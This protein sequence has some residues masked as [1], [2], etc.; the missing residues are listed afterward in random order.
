M[1][2][3][4][5]TELLSD[6][7]YRSD[8]AASS[9]RGTDDTARVDL[10]QTRAL[11]GG[12]Y[13]LGAALRQGRLGDVFAAEDQTGTDLGIERRVALQLIDP[14]VIVGST[15]AAELS[16]CCAA[17]RAA[18]HPNVAKV[19]NFGREGRTFFV[20]ME[21]LDGLSLRA[22]LDEAA[23][24][25]L[26]EDEVLP[27]VA[28][29]GEAIGYLHAKEIVHGSLR[30]TNVFVT[31]DHAVKV[32]D[33]PFTHLK[34]T[35][36]YYVEDTDDAEPDAPD[37]RDDVY[38]L[39][40]LTYELLSGRHPFNAN[41]PLDAHRAGLTPAPIDGLQPHQWAALERALALRRHERTHQVA[42]FVAA[43]GAAGATRLGSPPAILDGDTSPATPSREITDEAPAL[44]AA[45]LAPEL[46][47]PAASSA[48]EQ[49]D[50]RDAPSTDV[51]IPK[52]SRR[53]GWA[54]TVLVLIVAAVGTP[55]VVQES[56]APHLDSRAAG[57]SADPSSAKASQDRRPDTRPTA[58]PGASNDALPGASRSPGAPTASA[59]ATNAAVPAPEPAPTVDSTPS[60]ADTTTPR[61]TGVTTASAPS[62]PPPPFSFER[63]VVKVS[64]SDSA[65]RLTILRA[66]NS[67]A[68]SVVWW[69]TSETAIADEDF[70]DLGQRVETFAADET[71]KTIFVPIVMDS[72]P[73]A[74]EHFSV[75]LGEYGAD[76]SSLLVLA[77]ARIE[78]SDDD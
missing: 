63:S 4:S 19:L 25:A 61:A 40:C 52:P 6:R 66:A 76:R 58:G 10:E 18:P 46:R 74:T 20:V 73:E 77:A 31:L 50:L 51:A 8:R 1:R 43:F 42:E 72:E 54:I 36:P 41:S 71:R 21:L 62:E 70:A 16:R 2:E 13:R 27:I 53:I 14:T 38:G 23:P 65:V 75:Y 30:P 32:L 12:R 47:R 29:V 60:S 34:R 9:A 68:T 67:K 35:A 33:V 15:R 3:H 59:P 28:G 24:E 64:E 7:L 69:C 39:A 55:L 37:P 49:V 56:S 26:S 44:P 45:E 78:I 5:Y 11:V 17:L 22:I 48:V 57:A